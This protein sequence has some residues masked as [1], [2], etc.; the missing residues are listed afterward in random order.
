M[1]SKRKMVMAEKM[2][3]SD[4]TQGWYSFLMGGGMDKRGMN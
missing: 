1:Q 4:K 2:I 3:G